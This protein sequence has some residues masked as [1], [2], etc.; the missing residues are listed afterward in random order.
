[1]RAD[2]KRWLRVQSEN[3][4]HRQSL[5]VKIQKESFIETRRDES[6]NEG[7]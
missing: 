1:M 5:G 7:P 3:S 6:Q 2:A 4:D